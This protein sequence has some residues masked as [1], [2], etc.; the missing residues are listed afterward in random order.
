MAD[1][2]QVY[3]K[4]GPPLPLD[5]ELRLSQDISAFHSL[6]LLLRCCHVVS[7]VL[8]V[9]Q[10]GGHL[11]KSALAQCMSFAS[12]ARRSRLIAHSISDLQHGSSPTSSF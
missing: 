9:R 1:I 12:A 4:D 8:S 11:G 2:F 10:S 6:C 7:G 3:S 5:S